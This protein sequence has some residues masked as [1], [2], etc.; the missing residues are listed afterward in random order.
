MAEILTGGKF[1][2]GRRSNDGLAVEAVFAGRTIAA[3]NCHVPVIKFSVVLY[4]GA[5]SLFGKRISKSDARSGTNLT[6]AFAALFAA[7]P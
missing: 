7:M 5:L 4:G 1:Y 6:H 2:P 3:G